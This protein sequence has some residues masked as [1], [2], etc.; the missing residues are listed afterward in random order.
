MPDNEGDDNPFLVEGAIHRSTTLLY[1]Q[2]LAGK[3]TLAASIAMAVAGQ[4]QAWLGKRIMNHGHAL[5]VA[6]D[7]DRGGDYRRRLR[8]AGADNI[9]IYAPYQPA[10]PDTWGDAAL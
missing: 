1:G 5:I 6:G 8:R 4:D 10:I 7:Q 9:D 2:T 3:S